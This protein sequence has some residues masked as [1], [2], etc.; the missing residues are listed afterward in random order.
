MTKKAGLNIPSF[1]KERLACRTEVFAGPDREVR[2]S[3][4]YLRI[5]IPTDSSPLQ[6]TMRHDINVAPD[7]TDRLALRDIPLLVF[8]SFSGSPSSETQ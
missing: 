6:S 1:R 2:L 8:T 4:T 5:G 3:Y 7:V